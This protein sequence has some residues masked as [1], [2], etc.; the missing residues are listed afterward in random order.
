MREYFSNQDTLDLGFT[1]FM[2]TGLESKDFAH[3]WIPLLNRLVNLSTI[4]LVLIHSMEHVHAAPYSDGH[5][6]FLDD[7]F[8]D[9]DLV[10]TDHD[11]RYIWDIVAKLKLP[12]LKSV[13][14][15]NWAVGASILH[16][17]LYAHR[18]S[19]KRIHMEKVSLRSPRR[20]DKRG[21][22]FIARACREHLPGLEDLRLSD[23]Y[24]P[25]KLDFDRTAPPADMAV[26]KVRK[27]QAEEMASL[28]GIAFGTSDDS[29]SGTG[30]EVDEGTEPVSPEAEWWWPGVSGR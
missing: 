4:R 11:E 19:L 1:A 25:E 9:Y 16:Y 27:L 10:P 21:W 28:G 3:D 2:L 6:V 12:K 30:S 22:S 8:L 26:V 18:R 17:F 15:K 29:E 5:K 7:L 20:D 14:L 24:T 13:T 23:L